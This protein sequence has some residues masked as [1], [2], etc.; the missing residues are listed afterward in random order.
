MKTLAVIGILAAVVAGIVAAGTGYAQGRNNSSRQVGVA[1]VSALG[2]GDTA[3]ACRLQTEAQ[4]GGVPCGSLHPVV[5]H[6]P[7][8]SG[9][10]RRVAARTSAEQVGSVKV[11]DDTATASV[12]AERRSS[13]YRVSL[14]LNRVNGR[15]RVGSLSSGRQVFS[16]AGLV[17]SSPSVPGKLW[18]ACVRPIW[19]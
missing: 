5:H 19:A 12:T 11:H 1:W 15:W 17:T 14:T 9:P 16:P 10:L 2:H 13:H 4:V 7:K 8:Q 18:L 3:A 6:C